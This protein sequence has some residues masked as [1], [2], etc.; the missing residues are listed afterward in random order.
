MTD[1][2][3]FTDSFLQ[4]LARE[5]SDHLDEETFGVSELAEALH[6]SRSS[7]L[8]KVK[9]ATGLS[10]SV[11]MREIRLYHGKALL[12]DASLTVSEVAYRV[13]FNSTSYFTKCYREAYGYPPGEERQ[14]TAAEPAEEVTEAPEVAR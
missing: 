14:Q 5:V 6:M 2:T 8:R 4:Q 11:L 13:G 7:L 3:T 9:K 10:A 1:P 12:Q